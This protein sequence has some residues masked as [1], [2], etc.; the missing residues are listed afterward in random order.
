MKL[1]VCEGGSSEHIFLE[2]E[3]WI[4]I[5]KGVAWANPEGDLQI[6]SQRL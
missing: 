1:W 4:K 5:V 2:T 6:H 3:V